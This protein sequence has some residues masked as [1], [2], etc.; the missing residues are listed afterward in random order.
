MLLYYMMLYLGLIGFPDNKIRGFICMLE[1]GRDAG[2]E[3]VGGW[4]EVTS[5]IEQQTEYFASRVA[6][7]LL[8]NR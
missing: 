3:G 2:R 5:D 6:K 1:L 4:G 7:L 8:C